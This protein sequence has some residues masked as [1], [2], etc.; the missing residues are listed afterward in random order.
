MLELEGK[1]T[2]KKKI[3]FKWSKEKQGIKKDKHSMNLRCFLFQSTLLLQQ[4]WFVLKIRYQGSNSNTLVTVVKPEGQ[5]YV[6][7]S[8]LK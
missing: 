1:Q 7:R 2:L 6:R 3:N 8:V 4:H 5:D